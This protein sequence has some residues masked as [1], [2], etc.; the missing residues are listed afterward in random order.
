MQKIVSI[1]AVFYLF[2]YLMFFYPELALYK[3]K[4]KQEGLRRPSVMG[5]NSSQVGVSPAVH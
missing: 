5:Q 4:L 3:L 2:I 1:I